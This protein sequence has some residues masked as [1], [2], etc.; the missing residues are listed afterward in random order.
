MNIPATGNSS[1]TIRFIPAESD[2][3]GMEY[4]NSIISDKRPIWGLELESCD[5]GSWGA[6][7][8]DFRIF[9]IFRI[10]I[11]PGFLPMSSFS[12]LCDVVVHTFLSIM[13]HMY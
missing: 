6:R 7:D 4:G 10:L 9:R 3:F 11:Q 5:H 8:S 2:E 12:H 1:I 13:A